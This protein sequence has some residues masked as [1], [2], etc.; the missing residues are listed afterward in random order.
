MRCRAGRSL[1]TSLDDPNHDGDNYNDNQDWHP[2][3]AVAPHPAAAPRAAIH[4]VSALCQ[5]NT[6]DRQGCRTRSPGSVS[7]HVISPDPVTALR[8]RSSRCRC[9]ASA[10][11]ALKLIE[12]VHQRL[13]GE[14]VKES[15]FGTAP[16]VGRSVQSS[17][18]SRAAECSPARLVKAWL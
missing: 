8:I 7:F 14:V 3:P 2:H 13:H 9:I 11:Q 1:A 4:H 15:F 16:L 5:R 6:G 12:M 17:V 10:C 18:K